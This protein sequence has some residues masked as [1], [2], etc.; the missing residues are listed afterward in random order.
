MAK[1]ED[2]TP[3]DAAKSALDQHHERMR[4]VR[5]NTDAEIER[6]DHSM[7]TPTQSENDYAAIG[8]AN[9]GGVG[10]RKGVEPG[11]RNREVPGTRDGSP[12]SPALRQPEAPAVTR[13]VNT[14][15]RGAVTPTS[16]ETVKKD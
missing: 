11:Q 13:D 12:D 14:N 7:P 8:G 15:A 3:E 16:T 10:V 5:R 4:E 9:V 2:Y 1:D 6:M